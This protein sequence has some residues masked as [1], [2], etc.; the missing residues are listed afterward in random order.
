MRSFLRNALPGALGIAALV[1]VWHLVARRFDPS[2]FPGP[3]EV[4]AAW[5]E[6]LAEGQLLGHIKTSLA[7]FAI[8]YAIAV[9]LGVPLGVTLGYWTRGLRF[10]DPALQIL[11]PISP[12]AWFPL[13]VLWFGVGDAPAVFIIALAAFFPILLSTVGA[14]RNVPGDYLKVA[15]TFGAKPGFTARKVLLPAAFPAIVVGLRIA[16]GVAWIH[17]VAGEMLGSQAGLGFL[18][19]DARNFLRTD[20]IVAGMLTIGVLGLGVDR[21][22]AWFE[23]RVRRAWGRA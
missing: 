6:Q 19:V 13:A 1:A 5:Q 8:A 9:A 3:R 17:L 18:I 12:I 11:R 7:R 15:A 20:L 2:Q 23:R 21:L 4:A 16:L 10:V 14:V 22:M